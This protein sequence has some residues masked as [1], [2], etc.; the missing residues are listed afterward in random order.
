MTCSTQFFRSPFGRLMRVASSPV[1]RSPMN[2]F[3]EMRAG[4]LRPGD[5]GARACVCA[6]PTVCL[7]ARASALA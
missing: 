3:M 6:H 4:I 1:L 7:G 5:S 2:R